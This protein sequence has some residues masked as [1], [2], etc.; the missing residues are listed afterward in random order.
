MEKRDG[1]MTPI[2]EVKLF[3]RMQEARDFCAA[4][5]QKIADARLASGEFRM[6]AFGHDWR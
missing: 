4:E 2:E 1:K 3:R 6:P 5:N